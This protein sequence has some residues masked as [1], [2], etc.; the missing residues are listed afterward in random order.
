MDCT[1]YWKYP[2]CRVQVLSLFCAS[3]L[4]D[5]CCWKYYSWFNLLDLTAVIVFRSKEHPSCP[6]QPGCVRAHIESTK[7][8]SSGCAASTTA[9]L[10]LSPK[11][12]HDYFVVTFCTALVEVC[13]WYCACETTVY[14]QSYLIL[15]DI[16]QRGWMMY[17]WRLYHWPS[18]TS[19]KWRKPG[20]SA[21]IGAYWLEGLGCKLYPSLSSSFGNSDAEQC[22]WYITYLPQANYHVLVY[23][24]ELVYSTHSNIHLSLHILMTRMSNLCPLQVLGSGLHRRIV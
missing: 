11:W 17:R 7:Q 23:S 14:D 5:S 10:I 8:I 9:W 4:P 13:F 12:T 15:F 19:C 24:C 3:T 21:A 22:R 18:E 16:N 20:T 6:P 2:K 1:T